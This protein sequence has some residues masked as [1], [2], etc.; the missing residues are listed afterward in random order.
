MSNGYV[1]RI[2]SASHVLLNCSICRSFQ[3][4]KKINDQLAAEQEKLFGSKPSP[5]RPQSAKKPPGPRANGGAVN[6]TPNRRLS[7]QQQNGVRSGSRDGRRESV[8]P[9]A[10]V[11]YV[12]IAKDDAASQAS[13]T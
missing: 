8:R 11:N 10:L 9:S 6:G 12:A 3:D 4:Q 2:I 7:V 13:S 5:A 1:Q